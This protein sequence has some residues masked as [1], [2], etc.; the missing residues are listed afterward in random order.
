[1][2]K[3]VNLENINLEDLKNQFNEM[4]EAAQKA[5]TEA[6]EKN[7]EVPKQ[8]LGQKIIGIIVLI[9]LLLGVGFIAL[10]NL[11]MLFLPKNSVTLIV[12]DQNGDAI[13]G[14]TVHFNGPQIYNNE[15]TD[16]A[17]LTILDVKPGDYIVTF[18]D[19]PDG[20]TCEKIMDN[21][22]LNVDGKVKLEYTCTKEK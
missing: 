20:Y 1:M 13:N 3:K 14:L 2:S 22:T 19:I 5:K 12:K 11:D 7:I 8:S 16:I 4:K 6:K 10:S 15:F 17:D 18:E 21:F 9:A